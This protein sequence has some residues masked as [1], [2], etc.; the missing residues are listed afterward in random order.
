MHDPAPRTIAEFID[1]WLEHAATAYPARS[2]S[3]TLTNGRDACRHLIELYGELPPAELT[4]PRLR[5]VRLYMIEPPSGGKGGRGLSRKVIGDRLSRIRT[6]WRWGIDRGWLAPEQVDALKIQPL[7]RGRSAAR[8]TSPVQP[9]EWDQIEAIIEPPEG[10]GLPAA[11]AVAAMLRVQWWSAMRPGEVCSMRGDEIDTS[12]EP[13]LYAPGSHKTAWREHDRR[14]LLGPRAIS[15]LAS[16][17]RPAGS[18]FGYR[19][20]SYY[21]AVRRACRRAG[22]EHFTT[23]QV[24]HGAA[25]RIRRECGGGDFRGLEVAKTLLGHSDV[26]TTEIYAERDQAAARKYAIEKG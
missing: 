7:R 13:W 4:A 1:R 12:S 14:I 16:W 26:S 22:V 15:V 10:R 3:S 24:R 9:V 20:S 18:L 5:A 23:N 11:G 2:G 25:T 6:I 21:N 8:E 19:Q 17:I